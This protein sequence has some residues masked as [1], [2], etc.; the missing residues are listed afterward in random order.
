M[1]DRPTAA[2]LLDAAAE[3]LERDVMT[4]LGGRK[5]FL[6]RV[7]VNVLRILEREARLEPA[8]I[9]A[10]RRRLHELLGED[11]GDDVRELNA[12]LSEAIRRGDLEDR[13]DELIDALYATAVNK[14]RIANPRWLGEADRD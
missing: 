1:Q 2:E 12:T 10:E 11:A 6:V 3:F 5:G 8:A 7:S 13:T 14:L 4:E 9:A